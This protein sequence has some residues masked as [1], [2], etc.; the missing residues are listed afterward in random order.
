MVPIPHLRCGRGLARPARAVHVG[1]ATGRVWE[2]VETF[3]NERR[4]AGCKTALPARRTGLPG[5]GPDV[6]RS[7]PARRAGAVKV[8][9]AAG[10]VWV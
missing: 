3:R 4:R 8:G 7:T 6:R 5:K 1:E 10:R 9:E 2:W